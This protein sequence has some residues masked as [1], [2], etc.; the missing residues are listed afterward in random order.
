MSG[1]TSKE[2]WIEKKCFVTWDQLV[3]LVTCSLR[4]YLMIANAISVGWW[5]TRG[6]PSGNHCWYW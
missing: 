3:T 2:F 4:G 6:V 5:N 1:E